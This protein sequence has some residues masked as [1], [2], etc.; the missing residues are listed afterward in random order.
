MYAVSL[1]VYVCSGLCRVYVCQSVYVLENH[2]HSHQLTPHQLDTHSHTLRES[3]HS[4]VLA[5]QPLDRVRILRFPF[6]GRLHSLF[7]FAVIRSLCR[8]THLRRIQNDAS[9]NAFARQK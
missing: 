2:S 5:V 6:S 1:L 9:A 8:H 7:V 4:P 3:N